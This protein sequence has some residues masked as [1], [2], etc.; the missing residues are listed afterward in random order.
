MLVQHD[1]D[2]SGFSIFDTLRSDGRR[3]KF[4]NK[5]IQILDLGLRLRDVEAMGLQAEPVEHK[6]NWNKRTKTLMA[7]GAGWPEIHFLAK[8]RVELNA[9]AADVFVGFLERKLAEHGVR[10]VMP[11][12]AT[13]ERQAR[14]VLEQDLAKAALAEN[15]ARFQAE[16]AEAELPADLMERACDLQDRNPEMPW[17]LAVAAVVR[18]EDAA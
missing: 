12:L 4:E 8:R 6:G 3:Y 17:D 18:G 16:A 1:F 15:Q 11:D 5:K 13:L 14:R 2:V 9:M 7:H 10:K